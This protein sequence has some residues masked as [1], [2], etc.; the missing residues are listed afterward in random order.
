[1]VMVM[2]MVMVT[3]TKVLTVTVN[4]M[5]TVRSCRS[6]CG[7]RCVRSCKCPQLAQNKGCQERLHHKLVRKYETIFN[8]HFKPGVTANQLRRHPGSVRRLFVRKKMLVEF[9]FV[10][11]TGGWK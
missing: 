11:I 1:M 6:S 2:V 5:V 3:V 7:C 8:N 10:L 9:V 4:M